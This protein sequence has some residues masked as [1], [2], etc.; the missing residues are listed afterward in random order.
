MAQE[1]NIHKK[2]NGTK[3]PK[4]SVASRISSRWVL[5]AWI[6]L[7]CAAAALAFAPALSATALSFDDNMYL[8]ENRLVQN[9]SWAHAGRFFSEVLE[10]STATISR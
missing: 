7:A 2:R 1:R 6:A 5:L 3:D 10:P 8:T 4:A 9:P